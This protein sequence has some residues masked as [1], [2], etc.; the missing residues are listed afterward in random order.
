MKYVPPTYR[1]TAF[2]CPYCQA[3]AQQEWYVAAFASMS[4]TTNQISS[5]HNQIPDFDV[6]YCRQ[7]R[8][9]AFWY[10][11]QLIFPAASLAPFPS[12]DMPEDIAKDFNEARDVLSKSPRLSAALL[13]LVIQK[14][15]IL[16]VPSEKNLNKAI[17][18]LVEKG[19]ASEVQQALD[20][21]RVIGNNAVHPGNLDLR[22]DHATALALFDLVNF[23]V[24]QII[25]RP[26]KFADV[27]NKLSPGELKQIADRDGSSK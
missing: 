6:S 2:N 4:I 25:T 5:Y 21:V 11:T 19:L 16:L 3:F 24:E 9:I 10:L 12:E 7:C 15:C 22:D 14:L 8:S 13:R 1:A 18:I 27:Y 20:T 17:G 26:R 23:I